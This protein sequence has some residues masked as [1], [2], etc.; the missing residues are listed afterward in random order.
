MIM[1]ISGIGEKLHGLHSVIVRCIETKYK[2]EMDD[3]VSAINGRIISYIYRN[4]DRDVFARDLEND[5]MVTRS[6]VSKVTDT[7]IAKGLIERVAVE[8]DARLKKLVL[9][10]KAEEYAQCI[11]EEIE[12]FEKMMLDGFSKE[13]KKQLFSYI[14]R[15][16]ENVE[17][18]IDNKERE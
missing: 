14:D 2:A 6:T 4:H 11:C 7:M 9:T 18:N 17:K 10:E 3:R 12:S 5:L 15:M 1:A 13:E 8:H 16:K